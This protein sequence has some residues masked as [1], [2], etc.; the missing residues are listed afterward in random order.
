MLHIVYSPTAVKGHDSHIQDLVR[1]CEEQKG[2]ITYL[3][4]QMA[5]QR[6]ELE[7]NKE[8]IRCLREN[9]QNTRDEADSLATRYMYHLFQNVLLNLTLQQKEKNKEKTK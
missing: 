7:E 5:D 9:L 4:E 3:Y 6:V 2:E 1:Q 8:Q